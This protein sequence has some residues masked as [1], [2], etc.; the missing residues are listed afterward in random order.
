M[1]NLLGETARLRFR[2]YEERD[3]TDLFEYLSDETVVRFEPYQPMTADQVREELKSRIA[4]EE[5]IA[6][7][8]KSAGK[9]IGNV[10]L[11]RRGFPADGCGMGHW[12]SPCGCD[13]SPC[14]PER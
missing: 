10:Y 13:I 8:E 7:E 6:V 2:R 3:F 14:P 1:E 12:S 9:L 4:S 11:G 5:M